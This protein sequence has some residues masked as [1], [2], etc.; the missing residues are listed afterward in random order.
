MLSIEKTMTAR[1][2]GMSIYAW[3]SKLGHQIE[4]ASA[5]AA[6]QMITR[7]ADGQYQAASDSRK[8][9]VPANGVADE[10]AR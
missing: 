7:Q 10:P 4:S 1:H 8:G 5:G 3:M 9:G 2:Q 6:V